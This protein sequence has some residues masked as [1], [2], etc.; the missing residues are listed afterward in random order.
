MV[1]SKITVLIPAYN[2]EHHIVKCLDSI[3]MQALPPASLIIRDDGSSDGTETKIKKWL[4]QHNLPWKVYAG[5]NIGQSLGR[6]ELLSHASTKYVMFFDADDYLFSETVLAEAET[7][8]DSGMDV[9]FLG[10]K[11][12]GIVEAWDDTVDA[13]TNVLMKNVNPRV[14][15]VYRRSLW[16]DIDFRKHGYYEDFYLN[17]QVLLKARKSVWFDSAQ[18]YRKHPNSTTNRNTDEVK[19]FL[20][21]YYT[22][23][24]YAF[25]RDGDFHEYAEILKRRVINRGAMHN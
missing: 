5:P 8:L 16:E 4:A 10:S 21:G 11:G 14:T 7:E 3:K 19:I 12:L 20:I 17:T 24:S 15:N 1:S 18:F 9:V 13:L 25:L 6:K 23:L 22:K 2:V